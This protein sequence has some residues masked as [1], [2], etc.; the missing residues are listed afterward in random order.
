MIWTVFNG[1]CGQISDT[2]LVTV[3]Q[4]VIGVAEH[5]LAAAPVLAFDVVSNTML[6]KNVGVRS[7]LEVIDQSGRPVFRSVVGNIRENRILLS[8]I[9]P[10]AYVV[11]LVPGGPGEALRIVIDH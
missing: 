8:G 2:A 11:R 4:C 1:T 10:G 9:R 6:V 7:A 3:E 5:D